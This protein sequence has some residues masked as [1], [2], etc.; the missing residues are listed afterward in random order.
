MNK[1][2]K[3]VLLGIAGIFLIIQFLPN[4]LPENN[5]DLSNDLVANTMAPEAIAN[6]LRKACYDCHSN[7]TVYP[8]YSYVAPVSWLVVKDVKE[9]REELNMSEWGTMT[10]RKQVRAL[11]DMAEEVEK[12][13]MPLKIYTVI[14]QSARLSDEEISLL[15]DWTKSVSKDLLGSKT[16]PE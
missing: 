14:H 7:Q 5:E 10:K 16:E 2:V 8:W 1:T 15:S 11:N 9:G 13:A 12:R 4:A 3:K 6:I